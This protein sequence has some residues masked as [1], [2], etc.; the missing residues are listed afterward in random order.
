M[1]VGIETKRRAAALVEKS[2]LGLREVAKMIGTSY[3]TLWNF[4]YGKTENFG[5]IQN[6][7]DILGVS[8]YHLTTG[9]FEDEPR[10]RVRAA[11]PMRKDAFNLTPSPVEVAKMALLAQMEGKDPQAAAADYVSRK[12]RELLKS[13]KGWSVVKRA[14]QDLT[15]KI[16]EPNKT[17]SKKK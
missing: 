11:E 2:G 17:P 15:E 13:K 6:L 4:L 1:K 14:M 10:H 8:L 12:S 3:S 16:A 7:A 5:K 9:S